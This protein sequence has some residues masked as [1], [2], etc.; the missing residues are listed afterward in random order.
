MRTAS[1]VLADLVRTDATRPRVTFYDDGPGPGQGERIELSGRVLANWVAKAGNALQEAYD[2]A[3][4]SLVRLDLPALHWRTAY[5]ALAVWAVG[6]AVS[7]TDDAPADLVVTDD[8]RTTA[9]GD[10][11]LVTLPALAQSHPGPVPAGAMDEARELATYGDQLV[12]WAEPAGTDPALVTSSGTVDH[13][14]LVP[15][16]G[17]PRGARVR[18]AGAAE[19]AL[20]A[21]LGAWAV[22]GSVLLIHGGPAG[23]PTRVADRLTTEGVTV[24]L[25]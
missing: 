25:G 2:V 7:V 23:D 12:A 11:I 22:D 1:S 3:P 19:V 9:D 6:A 14:S 17:W 13:A 5:W 10:V 20:P 16:R 4:G 15:D 21:M 24:D 18:V 8:P